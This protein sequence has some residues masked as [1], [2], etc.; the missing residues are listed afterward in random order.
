MN[1]CKLI[2]YKFAHHHLHTEYSPLDAPVALKDLVE[3]TKHL[4]YKT[5]TVTDH[6]TVSSWV[7]VAGLCKEAGIRPIFG[8]E[9]YF[10]HDRKNKGENYHIVLIAKNNEGIKNIYRMTEKAW[11]DGFYKVPRIDWELLEKHHDGVIC[12]TACVGGLIPSTIR[13]GDGPDDKAT[14]EQRYSTALAHARRLKGIFGP[15]L[16][17][18]IQYHGIPDVEKLAY[19]GVG[20]IGKE[21]GIPLL[22]TNDVHYLRKEDANLQEALQ[23]LCTGKCIKDPGRM[24]HDMNQLY[25]KSQDEMLHIFGGVNAAAIQGSLELADKC[26]AELEFGKVQL[27]SIEVPKEY[28]DDMEFLE[29][30][31]REGMRRIGKDGDPVY[32]ARFKEEIDVMK[33]LKDK[34]H[35]FDRYFLVVWDYVTWAWNNG[36]RVGVGRGSGAGSLLLY[37]LRITGVDPILYDLMFERFLDVERNEMP[38][39]DIDFDSENGHK[40]YEYACQKYGYDKVARIGTFTTYGVAAAIKAAFKTFDPGNQFEKELAEQAKAA[41]NVDGQKHKGFVAKDVAKVSNETYRMAGE[42]TK[43]LPR[44]GTNDNPDPNCT[45]SKEEFD[46]NPEE[47]KWVYND[48]Y[49]QQQKRE[50]PEV[51]A[52]AEGLE[53]LVSGKGLHAA[54]RLIT[55]EPMVDVCPQQR[56]KGKNTELSADEDPTKEKKITYATVYDMDD[57]EKLGLVKFDFL[58]TN[59]LSVFNRTLELIE[60]RTG[61]RIDIDNLVPNDGKAIEFFTKGDTLAIFQFESNFMIKTLRNMHADCFED[62]IAANALGRPGP[63][64]FIDE[65]CLRKKGKAVTY[66]IPALEPILKT[67]LGIIV[68]QEQ[69]MKACRILAG[70]SGSEADKVRKAMGKKKRDILDKMK[71]KFIKGCEKVGSCSHAAAAGLWQQM[72][73][74][75]QYAFNRAHACGY[76]YCAYQCAYLKAHYPSEYM[77]SQLNV[78]SD[79]NDGLAMAEKYEHGLKG[80]G[81]KLLP[82]DVNKS[83]FEYKV[84]DA[85][86]KL[87][88]RRG[89]KGVKGVRGCVGLDIEAGAPYKDM[90]DYC[91]RSGKGGGKGAV[92]N[93]VAAGAFDWMLPKIAKMSGRDPKSLN[94]HDIM[95]EYNRRVKAAEAE[96]KEKGARRSEMD[97]IEP[98]FLVEEDEPVNKPFVLTM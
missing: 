47:K 40:V 69:V 32:E 24:K 64:Q 7:K 25:L 23:T 9:G 71:E 97:G 98:V 10:A 29:H 82:L 19:E 8:V 45:F 30:L 52:F 11:M 22:G 73:H 26:V 51:Y 93:L 67:T 20:R 56:A 46:K 80:L 55:Q 75:A 27:P 2:N 21:V 42:V 36:I 4:G 59:A 58:Q 81:I 38:D 15:D 60:K 14:P 18:E 54:G 94:R 53:G 61:N 37:C 87:F 3:Y 76:S 12:T 66:A 6:G 48:P 34:G 5:L 89:F 79:S 41:H 50:L 31:A 95:G 77:A 86:G 17:A 92:E 28:R 44:H 57:C 33:T 85:D 83:R 16:Y 39:I 49:F 90:F 72:E 1:H 62:V 43:H 35:R 13:E 88:V 74:F 78:E 91:L 70:F 96:K 68:Y 65:Y 84:A 63:M